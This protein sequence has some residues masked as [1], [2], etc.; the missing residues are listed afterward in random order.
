MC[1]IVW[2][3][4]LSSTNSPL[5]IPL[6]AQKP[7]NGWYHKWQGNQ[8]TGN[9]LAGRR[10]RGESHPE[11]SSIFWTGVFKV[12][13]LRNVEKVIVNARLLV[14]SSFSCLLAFMYIYIYLLIRSWSLARSSEK[15]LTLLE[16][17]V[18]AFLQLCAR[19]EFFVISS[20]KFYPAPALHL[21]ESDM[22]R[23]PR[24]WQWHPSISSFHPLAPAACPGSANVAAAAT[25]FH[26]LPSLSL[27]PSPTVTHLLFFQWSASR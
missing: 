9:I 3:R 19:R 7:E 8:V 16:I 27:L 24:P 21:L 1:K 22:L 13:G 5:S 25:H 4:S 20:S 2:G 15:Q 23:L 11:N 26:S 17:C 18:F 6:P 14:S 12:K 10:N